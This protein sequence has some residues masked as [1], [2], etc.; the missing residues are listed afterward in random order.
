LPF[1]DCVWLAAKPQTCLS[2]IVFGLQPSHKLG[3]S[4]RI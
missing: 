4:A 1:G 2:A 3:G